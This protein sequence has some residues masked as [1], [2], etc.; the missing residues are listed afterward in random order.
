MAMQTTNNP[1]NRF[2]QAVGE[3]VV[4]AWLAKAQRTIIDF[5]KKIVG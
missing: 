1:L 4:N 5:R 3:Y 2:Y